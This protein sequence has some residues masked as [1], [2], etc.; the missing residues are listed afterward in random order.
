MLGLTKILSKYTQSNEQKEIIDKNVRGSLFENYYHG[1]LPF[2]TCSDELQELMIKETL[3][4][5]QYIDCNE[6]WSDIK[7]S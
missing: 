5:T 2:D 7:V 1:I 6:I 3:E 4:S